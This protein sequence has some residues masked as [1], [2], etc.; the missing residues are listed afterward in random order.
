[1]FLPKFKIPGMGM[2]QGN[3]SNR[4]VWSWA[5]YDWANS[6]FATVVM[7]GF[8]PLFFKQYWA[9]GMSVGESSFMLGAANSGASMVVAVMAPVLGA[10]ADRGG[11][12]KR[13]LMF[14]A[15]TGVVMT[16]S[17]YWVAA[18]QWPMAIG[19]YVLAV[20]G[21]SGGNVFYD[22]LLPLVTAGRRL[23]VVSSLGFALGYLGGGLLFALDVSMTIWPSAFG[24]ADSNAA[25]RLSFLMVAVWWGLFSMPVLLFVSEPAGEAHG[26]HALLAGMC[27]L[28]RTLRK[29]RQM[30][31]IGLFLLAY[32]LYIDGVDTVMRM[33][34][35]FGLS[36]GFKA[37]TLIVPLL[38]TQ[39]VG[40]P[41]A[42]AFG[43]LGE[44]AG[45]KIGIYTGIGTYMLVII[46][47]YFISHA[48]EFYVLAA[49]IGLVQG[50]IQALS[51]SLY[52]RLIP[53]GQSAEY[54]GFYNMLGKFAAVIGPV[55][56]GYVGLLT[57]SPRL[58]ILSVLLLFA[59]GML[60][61]H[62]VDAGTSSSDEQK[63]GPGFATG[64]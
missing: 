3:S 51:R 38:I 13:F 49:A 14:F 4:G 64:A 54:F 29:A 45:P 61:L 1:M 2:V 42:L 24:L 8:F 9:S 6:A 26:G 50:G 15:T 43:R 34:V 44:K 17:L 60:V 59:A 58:S 5:L 52:A 56:M 36:L 47:A 37:N 62:L 12:R 7:A 10:I 30:K 32:W 53:A 40:F 41:A 33:A 35:D 48:W 46:W 20:S 23:D 22:A 28:Y 21:F 55:M 57:G 11:T 39:L 25:I 16:G 63:Q 27:Q 19:L 18:G 31:N